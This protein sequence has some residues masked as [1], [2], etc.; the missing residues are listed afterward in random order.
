MS[1]TLRAAAGEVEP[2]GGLDGVA[3]DALARW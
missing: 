2:Q 3:V 1:T